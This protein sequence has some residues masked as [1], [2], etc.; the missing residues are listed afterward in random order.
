MGMSNKCLSFYGKLQK[1]VAG[2]DRDSVKLVLGDSINNNRTLTV[3]QVIRFLTTRRKKGLKSLGT[4]LE[5][6]Y[7]TLKPLILR[8][9]GLETYRTDAIDINEFINDF[10]FTVL[11]VSGSK[12]GAVRRSISSQF[13]GRV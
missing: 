8:R 9:R 2:L 5:S 7:G 4:N 6:V 11:S 3:S 1:V 10:S 12:G 13:V